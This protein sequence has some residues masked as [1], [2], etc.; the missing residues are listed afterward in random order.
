MVR[1]RRAI[2]TAGAWTSDILAALGASLCPAA[3]AGDAGAAG[4]L[5]PVSTAEDW[6]GFNHA[7]SADDPA[8][9]WFLSGVYGMGSPGEGVKAGW[10]GVGPEIHPDRRTYEPD[11]ALSALIRRYAHEWLPGVD[12]SAMS[13]ITC[14]YTSTPDAVFVLDRVG[15]G[16]CRRRVLGARVQVRSRHRADPRGL[17]G[18]LRPTRAERRLTGRSRC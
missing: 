10:H 9:S 1:A 15:P 2:V 6:P 7:P 3:A 17:V 4:V 13:E 12:A 8:T 5:R 14:T 18:R 16:G 11:P